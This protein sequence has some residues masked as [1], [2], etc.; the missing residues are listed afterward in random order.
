MD[1]EVIPEKMKGR[2]IVIQAELENPDRHIGAQAHYLGIPIYRMHPYMPPPGVVDGYE[3]ARKWYR[4]NLGQLGGIYM[5][6]RGE[7]ER[8]LTNAKPDVLQYLI[9]EDEAE[10]AKHP[11]WLAPDNEAV[12]I[13]GWVFPAHAVDQ[14]IAAHD[15]RFE[16]IIVS[17][18]RHEKEIDRVYYFVNAHDHIINYSHHF[19]GKRPSPK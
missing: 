4:G 12:E 2:H 15:F 16:I 7:M 1:Q 5:M 3:S 9:T 6:H 13:G 19:R 8:V 14:A 18:T 17:V 10:R 11:D